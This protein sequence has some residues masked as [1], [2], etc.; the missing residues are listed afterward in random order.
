MVKRHKQKEKIS[1]WT[2]HSAQPEEGRRS[3][4]REKQWWGC[5]EGQAGRKRVIVAKGVIKLSGTKTKKKTLSE[6]V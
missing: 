4:L 6:A 1:N 3:T 2:C 5:R